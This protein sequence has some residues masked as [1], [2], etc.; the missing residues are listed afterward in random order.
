MRA[1]RCGKLSGR[2]R[3]TIGAR[4]SA[5]AAQAREELDAFKRAHGLR[6]GAVYPR[7]TLLQAGL[8]FCAAVFEALFS[9]A[10]FAEDDARGLLGG[11]IT[12]IGFSGANVTLRLSR[13][14]SW[15]ALSAA[16]ALPMKALGALGVRARSRR[17]R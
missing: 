7:S 14:L 3:R 15:P 11:A 13:G 6:R 17:S 2:A 5:R 12:A 8:L 16:R 4:P 9:A 10:L 1:W